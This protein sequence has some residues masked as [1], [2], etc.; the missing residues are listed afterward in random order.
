MRNKWRPRPA[1]E[2]LKIYLWN[3][4]T[5]RRR[6]YPISI[7]ILKLKMNFV[8]ALGKLFLFR[9]RMAALEFV[10]TKIESLLIFARP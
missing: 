5:T 9:F 1:G 4:L 7:K 3:K 10:V 6:N 8:F 2:S